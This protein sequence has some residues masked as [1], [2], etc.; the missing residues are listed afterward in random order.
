MKK[1]EGYCTVSE[2]LERL[3]ISRSTIKRAIY[4]KKIKAIKIGGRWFIEN[5]EIEKILK[6]GY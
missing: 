6:G 4:K 5:K 1:Y 2:A 3:P